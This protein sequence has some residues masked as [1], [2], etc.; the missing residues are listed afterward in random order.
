MAQNIVIKSVQE[1]ISA[2]SGELDCDTNR[3]DINVSSG[4]LYR[5]QGDSSWMMSPSLYRTNLF[6]KEQVLISELLRVCPDEFSG[7]SNFDALVKMQHYGMPTRLLDMTHNPLVALYFACE[8]Q[9]LIEKDGSVYLIKNIPTFWQ[10]NY[11]VH[12][13]LRYIFDFSS[14]S[15]DIGHF[16]DVLSRDPVILNS[17][18]SM[19]LKDIRSTIEHYLGK[20]PVIAVR[21]T[22]SNPRI[23]HQDGAFLLFGMQSEMSKVSANPGTLGKTY[24][25]FKPWSPCKENSE[26]WNQITEYRIPGNCKNDIVR[27]LNHLGISHNR[28]FPE[29][30]YQTD[31][32]KK[33]VERR[34]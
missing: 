17:I 11:A 30:Q 26:I 20:E 25:K 12:L 13:V 1:F 28:L 5:G 33:Y 23:I 18:G 32:V 2:I 21:P 31:F 22:L 7:L 14:P 24:V 34:T 8:D 19:G 16:V 15:L 10:R 9:S 6:D 4:V 27:N 3:L 29:L